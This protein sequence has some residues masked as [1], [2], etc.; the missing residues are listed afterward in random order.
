MNS[1]S[2]PVTTAL[3]KNT[4]L[5]FVSEMLSMCPSSKKQTRREGIF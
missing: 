2:P 3:K 5:F 1:A 4:R